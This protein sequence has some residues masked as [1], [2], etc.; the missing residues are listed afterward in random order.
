MDKLRSY[1]DKFELISEKPIKFEL[2]GYMLSGIPDL[3]L[4]PQKENDSL[5]VWDYKTGKYS[6]DK[7]AG[8]YFQLMA[9]AYSQYA[10]GIILPERL[11]KLVI[12]F[13]DEKKIVEYSV[14]ALDVEKYLENEL[15]KLSRLGE[16]N[17]D[18]CDYCEFSSICDR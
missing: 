17:L 14:T 13:V 12:L 9:Y 11:C 5:E 16:K 15:K 7:L 3:I 1:Q 4:K 8:Y 2:F 10:Q 18:A 6:E